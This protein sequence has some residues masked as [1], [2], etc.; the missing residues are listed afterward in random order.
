MLTF[1]E[2]CESYCEVVKVVPKL[3]SSGG[4]IMWDVDVA[5]NVTCED[6]AELLRSVFPSAVT[7]YM[8]ACDGKGES[9]LKTTLPQQ[10]FTVSLKTR[11]G[12]GIIH[13][14]AGEVRGVEF[15]VNEKSQVY[16]AKM[17]LCHL[18]SEFYADLVQSLG[19]FV[20]V[21]VTPQ[22][23]DLPLTSKAEAAQIGDVV[24]ADCDGKE[25]YGVYLS[26]RYDEHTVE[27]CNHTYK[28]QK[29]LSSIKVGD[30]KNPFSEEMARYRK[31]SKVAS[32][33]SLFATLSVL[34]DQGRVKHDEN[35][36]VIDDAVIDAALEMEAVNG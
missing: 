2:S 4:G 34:L 21:T 27:D 36:F 29:I 35:G 15:K 8:R 13:K 31:Q 18:R 12:E 16:T 3:D 23:Q 14:A 30:A 10:L 11:G 5:Y 20:V 24:V 19:E 28:A 25:V 26:A 6:E 32:W 22:Q 1:M 33:K 17:R 9:S 7:A